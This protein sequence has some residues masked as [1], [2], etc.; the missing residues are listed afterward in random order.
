MAAPGLLPRL[1]VLAVLA[2]PFLLLL[3]GEGEEGGAGAAAAAAAGPARA[4]LERQPLGGAGAGRGTAGPAAGAPAGE[5]A[6]GGGAG[7]P[8]GEEAG[9]VLR[10]RVLDPGG[11]PLAGARAVWTTGWGG[12]AAGRPWAWTRSGE[13]GGD[14][15]LALPAG[16]EGVE[17]G[18]LQV[19]RAEGGWIAAPRRLRPP[20]PEEEVE[21]RAGAGAVLEVLVLEAGGAP[22]P[23]AT[24][25]ARSP[26][27]PWAARL[28]RARTGA[29]G[30]ARLAPLLPGE[31][32]VRA[33]DPRLPQATEPRRLRVEAA[34]RHEAV[35]AFARG[36]EV[37]VRAEGRVLDAAGR[38]LPGI[39][40]ELLG[41]EDERARVFTGPDGSFRFHGRPG[42][43]GELRIR[44][45]PE[46]GAPPFAPPELRG[47]APLRGLEFRVGG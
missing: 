47:P 21:V 11:R 16:P 43:G 8:G 30:R 14:G 29:D 22:L 7:P 26:D 35:L 15:R 25:E 4:P 46:A 37:A 23:G 13:T 33:L 24:V 31:V 27:P 10:L 45:L 18:V 1:A 28:W 32:E 20:W 19:D 17:F 5:E 6:A 9:P 44:P 34:A 12:P 40:V 39:A 42:Q 38:P 41:P 36:Q 2:S 3:E